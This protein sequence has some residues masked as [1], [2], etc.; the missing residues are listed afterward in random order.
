MTD[1]ELATTSRSA[2]RTT[3]QPSMATQLAQN[4]RNSHPEDRIQDQFCH[5]FNPT[6]HERRR[7]ANCIVKMSKKR[8]ATPI[9]T[10]ALNKKIRLT[11]VQRTH[12]P[13]AQHEPTSSLPQLVVADRSPQLQ[14][15]TPTLKGIKEVCRHLLTRNTGGKAHLVAIP[16]EC[17]YE[18]CTAIS[19]SKRESLSEEEITVRNHQLDQCK[20]S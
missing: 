20:S 11:A 17:T 14:K 18:I 12:S 16:T 6:D 7:E 4:D 5:S 2:I 8:L 1:L 3:E 13:R 19:W 10:P 9:T 15:I